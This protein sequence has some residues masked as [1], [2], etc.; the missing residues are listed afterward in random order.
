MPNGSTQSILK[1][2]FSEK[3]GQN[4]KLSGVSEHLKKKNHQVDWSS[5]KTLAKENNY[6]KCSSKRAY[7]IIKHK[8]KAPLL[9]RKNECQTISSIRKTI[10]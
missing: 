6:Q 10:L 2:E 3:V 5:I 1:I 4:D 9:N 7:F 8:D